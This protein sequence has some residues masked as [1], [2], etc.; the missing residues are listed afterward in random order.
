MPNDSQFNKEYGPRLGEITSEQFQEAFHRFGLGQ[1]LAAEPI[2]T[3]LFG[4]N[5]F[6]TSTEG[7]FVLRGKCHYDWQFPKE[8]F[9]AQLLHEQTDVPIPWPYLLDPSTDIFGWSYII[10]PRLPGLQLARFDVRGALFQKDK[11]GIAA[12]MGET[13][14]LLHAATWLWTGE[15]SLR[16]DT[17]TPLGMPYE[18]WIA[19]GIHQDIGAARKHS[20]RT[21]AA[22]VAWVEQV[23]MRGWDALGE[24]YTPSI[25]HHDFNYDNAVANQIDSRWLITG[26][27]DLMEAYAG[28][29]EADLCRLAAM[30][31]DEDSALARTY[32]QSYLRCRPPRAGFS[33]RFPVYMLLDRLIVWSY[34]QA[35]DVNWWDRSLTLREWA[36]PY[37][38][39]VS[40]MS[41][42]GSPA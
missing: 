15:Y 32:V 40:C 22:D 21:T 3:G 16:E 5:V 10:M 39:A 33:E 25:V 36:E 9:I 12:A 14:A 28:D 23:L 19:R 13:L 27:F 20:D 26:V 29:P 6:V 8:R 18:E 7:E 42:D 38:S 35:N 24:D 11:H 2:P 30:Y 1:F 41:C 31:L 4:Q 17:I 34:A 37:I